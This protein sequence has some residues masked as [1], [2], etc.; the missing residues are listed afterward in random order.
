MIMI[1]EFFNVGKE[2]IVMIMMIISAFYCDK[3][4]VMMIMIMIM[5]FEFFSVG[6]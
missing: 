5:I 4:T 6:K 2:M 1:F 3:G